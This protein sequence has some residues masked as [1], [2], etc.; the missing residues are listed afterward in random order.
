MKLTIALLLAV[1]TAAFAATPVRF[2][3]AEIRRLDARNAMIEI[4]G[5]TVP[6]R[7]LLE[8]VHV[9]REGDSFQLLFFAASEAAEPN[10]PRQPFKKEVYAEEMDYGAY[11]IRCFAL[12]TSLI[13]TT[14]YF[15]PDSSVII[16]LPDSSQSSDS[17]I[18]LADST[19]FVN[20]T[21]G[22]GVSTMATSARP[23][24]SGPFP[25]PF[26]AST[27][28]RLSV[29]Y[30]QV[31]TLTLHDICGKKV[32]ELVA[33]ELAAGEHSFAWD[34]ISFSSGI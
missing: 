7:P 10:T 17:S 16:F 13:D 8:Q 15:S 22:T 2:E 5:T 12:D 31:V 23:A 3:N 33:Q 20:Y 30:A 11:Q 4:S 14:F 34:A 32:A 19:F 26:N 25:N 28:F 9:Y 1:C 27:T 18:V 29:P 21:P 24:V 6:S